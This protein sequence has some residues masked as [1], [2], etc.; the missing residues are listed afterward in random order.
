MMQ[1]R[2]NTDDSDSR[3]SSS[4]LIDLRP[5]RLSLESTSK[6]ESSVHA[7]SVF[8]QIAEQPRS[9]CKPGF[10]DLNP[11][12][13]P[14]PRGN[15]KCSSWRNATAVL[16]SC[17]ILWASEGAS[18]HPHDNTFWLISPLGQHDSRKSE[19]PELLHTSSGDMSTRLGKPCILCTYLPTTLDPPTST[20][21]ALVWVYMEPSLCQITFH[22]H[23]NSQDVFRQIGP[24]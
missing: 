9:T 2:W 12:R 18:W 24:G 15:Y 14:R 13:F 7:L 22:D 3:G 8:R 10:L 20:D 19:R 5:Y 17:Y 11:W 21:I 23:V 6:D 4:V 16:G 1:P